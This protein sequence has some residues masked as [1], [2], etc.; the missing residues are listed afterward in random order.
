MTALLLNSERSVERLFHDLVVPYFG[1]HPLTR[2]KMRMR[3]I[4]DD[5]PVWE[6]VKRVRSYDVVSPTDPRRFVWMS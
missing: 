2:D 5:D 6:L 3:G 4:R 1:S